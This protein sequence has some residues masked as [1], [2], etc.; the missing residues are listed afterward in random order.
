MAFI[1]HGPA[2]SPIPTFA[3]YGERA[4]FPDILHVESIKDRAA[5]LNWTIAPH[6][7][8]YLHQFLHLQ[9][10]AGDMTIDGTPLRLDAPCVV[11]LPPGVVHS[12]RFMAGV[13]GHVLTL[14]LPEWPDLFGPG[15]D[16][17]AGLQHP[18][19][20]LAD[21]GLAR[22]ADR[23]SVAHRHAG[24]HRRLALRAAMMDFAL[25][26]MQRQGAAPTGEKGR[27]DPR[28]EQLRQMI[29]ASP[30]ITL[31]V[32]ACASRLGVSPRHLSRLCQD[33]TGMSAQA[34]IHSVILREACRLLAYTRMT[35]ASIG[36]RLGFDDPSY[37]S[38]FF[39]REMGLSPGTYRS[40]IGG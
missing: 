30:S 18:F 26:V 31:T 11:S 19:H 33:A 3:L 34:L 12:F 8:L 28:V 17:A 5:G 20:V 14:P 24:P 7:H 22:A 29:V 13:S 16:C 27:P 10:G 4:A 23:L 35:V 39:Q 21:A 37:F 9:N 2:P 32:E 40:R 1:G 25:A 38:R 36:H 15:A 6:R